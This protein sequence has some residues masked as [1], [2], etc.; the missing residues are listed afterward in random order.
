MISVKESLKEY[1]EER[2]GGMRVEVWFQTKFVLD[3]ENEVQNLD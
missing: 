3:P 1:K 2:E